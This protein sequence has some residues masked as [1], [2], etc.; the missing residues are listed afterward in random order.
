MVILYAMKVIDVHYRRRLHALFRK[1]VSQDWYLVVVGVIQGA[2]D[3]QVE[4][5][6]VSEVSFGQGSP[7]ISFNGL[8]YSVD[9]VTKVSIAE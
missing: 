9:D 6:I 5:G 1:N 8:T 7:S 4:G 3:S 2:K